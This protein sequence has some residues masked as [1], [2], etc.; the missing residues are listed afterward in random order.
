MSCQDAKQTFEREP[1]S[2]RTRKADEALN[3]LS[4][5]ITG[6]SMQ[7]ASRAETTF[8]MSTSHCVPKK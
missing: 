7:E 5:Q 6:E 8:R 3:G 2:Q 1:R 4:F